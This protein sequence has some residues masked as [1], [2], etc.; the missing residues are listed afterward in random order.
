MHSEETSFLALRA[1]RVTICTIALAPGVNIF[2]TYLDPPRRGTPHL[3]ELI[4]SIS[5]T[6][7]VRVAHTRSTLYPRVSA[8]SVQPTSTSPRARRVPSAAMM[9]LAAKM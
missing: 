7:P 4:T 6:E 3:N 8:R 2:R 1:L 5:A 9:R